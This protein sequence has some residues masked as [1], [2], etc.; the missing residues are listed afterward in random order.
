MKQKW[1]II[2]NCN[3]HKTVTK[4]H[5]EYISKEIHIHQSS[6]DNFHLI[7]DFKAKLFEETMKRFCTIST[8]V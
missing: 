6:Y 5:L 3:P 4:E 7:G 2:C 1:L 8:V